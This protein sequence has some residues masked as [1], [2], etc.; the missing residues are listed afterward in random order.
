ME[1]VPIFFASPLTIHSVLVLSSHSPKGMVDR[2]T[3]SPIEAPKSGTL[4]DGYW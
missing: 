4:P 1:R 3:R 2:N